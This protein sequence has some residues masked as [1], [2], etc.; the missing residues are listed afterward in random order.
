MVYPLF[1]HPRQ[2]VLNAREVR[3]PLGCVRVDWPWRADE[4]GSRCEFRMVS[5]ATIL[6]ATLPVFLIM[7][8]GYGLRRWGRMPVAGDGTLISLMVNVTYPAYILNAV[9]VSPALRQPGNVVPP[10]FWGAAFVVVGLG[11]GWLVA[12]L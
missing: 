7:A 6:G 5:Y 8:L 12:P 2:R 11:I 1:K 9:I 4:S 10:V 3:L